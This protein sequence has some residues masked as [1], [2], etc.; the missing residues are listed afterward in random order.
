[1]FRVS[2]EKQA[3]EG[4]SLDAQ[5]RQYHQLAE[6]HGWDTLA[7]FRGSES[8]TQAS[9]ERAVLQEVLACIRKLEPDA[10]YV[11]EQSRL[12][13]GDELEVAGLL[14]EL[15]E[16]QLKILI[17]G[18][19]RDL[20]SLDERF[21]VG[22]QSLVDRAEAERIKERHQRGKKEKA[23]R[24]LKNSG[25]TPY[26]YRNP[27]PGDPNRG[28][29]QIVPYE[30]AIVRRIFDLACE[31]R[32][33]RAI[34]AVLTAEGVPS[35]RGG[36][37]GKTT[38][39]RVLTNPAYR[40]CHVTG[41]WVAEP[42]SRTFRF[43]LDHPGAV[44]VEGAH[45]PIVGRD[46]WEAAQAV[47][48]APCTARPRMLTG[49]MTMNGFPAT[50]DSER[51][52]AYYRPP[53]GV[54]GGPWLPAEIVDSAVWN[55]FIQA[56][57]NPEFLNRVV[58]E[59]RT[60]QAAGDPAAER[61]RL[62]TRVAKLEAR[63]ARLVDMRADGEIDGPEFR[64]RADEARDHMRACKQQ[65]AFLDQMEAQLDGQWI[66]QMFAAAKLLVS[67]ERALS[68]EERRSVLLRAVRRVEV[69]AIKNPQNQ[70]K[71]GRGRFLNVDK[72]AWQIQSVR[73]EMVQGAGSRNPQL[74]MDH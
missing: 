68:L 7:A 65:L 63:L 41:A 21:M 58:A 8:A 32:A 27:P 71:D 20:S 1:M 56:I 73:F 28:R 35:P 42:G 70:G 69:H 4:A 12:T 26:G 33:V 40:G 30:A 49:L 43:D 54:R 39:I 61:A 23:L 59:A 9:R 74:A 16:R 25:P 44:V 2:T 24:G 6:R 53:R 29:L 67:S 31:G 17:G 50:G 52:K 51:G 62:T 37:W 72:T 10:I 3:N 45:D 34:A 66:R 13:R 14:R 5:E 36:R 46:V 38:V 19:V 15:R 18:V 48:P 22:I 55:A 64:K 47:Q 60:R 11:H 57:S